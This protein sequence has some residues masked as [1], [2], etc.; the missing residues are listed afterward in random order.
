V[1]FALNLPVIR[2]LI[3]KDWQLFQKQLAAYVL[4][5]LAALTL[6]GLATPWAFYL[7][8]LVLIVVLVAIACFA[9]STSLLVERKEQTL[10][11]VMSLPVSPL[12]F[13]LAKLLGN[14][15]T[16]GVPF[17][18]LLAGTLVVV[19]TTPLPDGLV[20]LALLLFG[21]VLLAY[22]VSLAVAMQV[23][24]EGWNI[25]A[26]IASMVLINPFLM[27]IGQIESISGPLREDAITWSLPALL[28]LGGQLLLSLAALGATAWWHGRKPAFY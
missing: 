9:I 12:D 25:F 5:G 14:L 23:E 19:L 2:L 20:V 1:N 11:F 21:H 10:A 26:M 17:V 3:M 13:T 7:G 4:A 6:L 28:I 15:L 22:S 8:S 16:F 27:L 24:S 18:I